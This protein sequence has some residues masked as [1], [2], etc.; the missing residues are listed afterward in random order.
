MD[1]GTR[2]RYRHATERIARSGHLDE[3]DVAA[4]AV[5]LAR[6]SADLR[7]CE[8]RAAHVGCYLIGEGLVELEQV[9]GVDVS[10][11]EGL[12]RVARRFPLPLYLG[13][14]VVITASIGAMLAAMAHTSGAKPEVLAW[15]SSSRCWPRASRR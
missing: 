11:V 14:I 15:L 1:F 3:A 6:A 12:R 5:V 8:D 9:A 13:A 4:K 7:G 10:V 2:D